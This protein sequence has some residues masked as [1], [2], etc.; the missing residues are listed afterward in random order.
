MKSLKI[1]L[2]P[3][4]AFF[5]MGTIFTAC[6]NFSQPKRELGTTVKM[7]ELL[8]DTSYQSKRVTVEGYFC[9]TNDLSAT[10]KIF[11]LPF[12]A[13]VTFDKDS[14]PVTDWREARLSVR[15][16]C[17]ED[18]AN[19]FYTPSDFT[20]KDLILHTNDGEKLPYNTKVRISGDVEFMVSAKKSF[21]WDERAKRYS[22][23]LDN[24]RIDKIN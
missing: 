14:L 15:L 17:E 19:T 2:F 18:G 13:N 8:Q 1:N 7:N 5:L 9:I 6:S 12:F 10:T 3:F 16:E 22:A 24:V 21:Y 23:T 4:L 20:A 11:T